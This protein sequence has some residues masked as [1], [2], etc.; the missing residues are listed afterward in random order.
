M[1]FRNKK[2]T[3]WKIFPNINDKAPA[4]YYNALGNFICLNEYEDEDDFLKSKS[5]PTLDKKRFSI[6]IHEYQHYIDQVST[7]WGIRNIYKIFGAYHYV[8]MGKEEDFYNFRE[9]T[10]CFK[11]DY[12]LD[13]YTEYYEDIFGSYENPWKFQITSGT[14]FDAAGKIDDTQPIPLITFFSNDGQKKVCRVPISVVSLLETTATNKEY[15]FL[16]SEALK[17]ESPY[18]DNQLKALSEQIEKKIYHPELALYSVAVHLTSVFLEISNPIIAYRISSVFAKVALNL[19]SELFS[20]IKIPKELG[21][22]KQWVERTHYLIKNADC[23]FA[24][25]LLIKNYKDE[26]GKLLGS[27]ISVDEI[28]SSSNL[29]NEKEVE[30]LISIEIETLSMKSLI[31]QQNGF[32]RMIADKVFFGSKFRSIAGIGQ[33]NITSEEEIAQFIREKPWL[34]YGGKDVPQNEHLDLNE[35]VNKA[36]FQQKLSFEEW[37][38][39]WQFC[40]ERIDAFSEIC[41]I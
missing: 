14:R 9:L 37:F 15:D 34:V 1:K 3:K 28:L 7:L 25:Y 22:T 33:Q 38:K 18:K 23:G 11:R 16:L 41:G 35:I 5:N 31:E 29:P 2:V 39:L 40:E 12:F 27:D 32:D 10:L 30:Q 4:G 20:A 13:Y 8:F 21:S 6:F 17:L 19:P 26:V 36:Q 24:F